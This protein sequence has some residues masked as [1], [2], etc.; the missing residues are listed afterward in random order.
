MKLNY[1]TLI[2]L[3]LLGALVCWHKNYKQQK[4]I[5]IAPSLQV[6][7]QEQLIVKKKTQKL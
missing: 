1:K 5:Q 4:E 7:E 3:I 2:C 6:K